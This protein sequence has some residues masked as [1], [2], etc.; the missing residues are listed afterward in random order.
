MIFADIAADKED[1]DVKHIVFS[2]GSGEVPEPRKRESL[3]VNEELSRLVMASA[4]D[5]SAGGGGVSVGSG[6]GGRGG[7]GSALSVG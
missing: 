6:A 5:R 7:S 4:A 1:E 2:E 3:D